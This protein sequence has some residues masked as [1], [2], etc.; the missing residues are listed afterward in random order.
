VLD[1]GETG[2]TL[3]KGGFSHSVTVSNIDFN[4]T[5]NNDDYDGSVPSSRFMTTMAAGENLDV[6]IAFGILAFQ[7]KVKYQFI[8]DKTSTF[9]MSAM[10]YY[11]VFLNLNGY[12]ETAGISIPFSFHT[13]KWTFYS[14]PGYRYVSFDRKYVINE[15]YK[16]TGDHFTNHVGVMWGERFFIFVDYGFSYAFELNDRNWAL[17][18]QTISLGVGVRLLNLFE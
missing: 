15:L 13:N 18:H 9:A 1:A 11:G 8:G 5:T 14:N 3:G 10:G 16:E 17:D 6:S 4:D 12:Q 2:R 7:G